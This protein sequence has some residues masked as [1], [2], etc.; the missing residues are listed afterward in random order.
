MTDIRFGVRIPNSGPLTSVPNM[1]K[2]AYAAEAM[3]FNSIWLHDHVVWSS[4]MHRHH[5]SSGSAEALAD[6]QTADFFEAL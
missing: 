3:G 1:V 4:E 6:E 2:S 5:I